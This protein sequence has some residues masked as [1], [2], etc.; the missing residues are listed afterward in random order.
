MQGTS[1]CLAHAW[2]VSGGSARAPAQRGLYTSQHLTQPGV[3][4]PRFLMEISPLHG[5]SSKTRWGVILQCS[6]SQWQR[7][8]CLRDAPSRSL[9]GF[10]SPGNLMAEPW[11]CPGKEGA[12]VSHST[13]DWHHGELVSVL[14]HRSPGASVAPERITL[15]GLVCERS[16]EAVCMELGEQH[17]QVLLSDNTWKM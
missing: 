15:I 6:R 10:L 1:S 5:W 14:C 13:S 8:V 17:A 7:H 3:P 9:E 2:P 16:H 12:A 4:A 11:R